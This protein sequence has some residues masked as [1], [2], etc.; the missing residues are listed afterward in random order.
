MYNTDDI[1]GIKNYLVRNGHTLSVAESVTSGH[2]QAALSLADGA[3]E[4][5]QGGITAYNLGQKARHLKIDPIHA[6][7][8]NCVSEKTADEMALH[9]L[10]LFSS[11]W[12]ISITGYAA[13]V[14]ALGISE[15]YAFYAV[16]FRGQIILKKRIVTQEENLMKAQVSLA[17]VLLKAFQEYL[18]GK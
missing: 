4:F 14:P 6:E 13:P 10:E 12:S 15:R 5:F 3:S 1:A 8:C 17:N 9:A 11:D 16:A 2:L 7:S 18:S